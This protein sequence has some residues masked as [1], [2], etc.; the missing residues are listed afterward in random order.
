MH[1]IDIS[2][3]D[4]RAAAAI[5][6]A[7]VTTGFFYGECTTGS[8]WQHTQHLSHCS[9][10]VSNHGVEP[11]IIENQW[12]QNRAFFDLP[13][14]EKLLILA[15]SNGRYDAATLCSQTI[16][17]HATGALQLARLFSA[18][19]TCTPCQLCIVCLAGATHPSLQKAWILSIIHRV[20][21]RKVHEPPPQVNL[22][23]HIHVT[24]DFTHDS[25]ISIAFTTSAILS[26]Y[27]QPYSFLGL[28]TRLSSGIRLQQMHLLV[29]LGSKRVQLNSRCTCRMFSKSTCQTRCRCT[30][31]LSI[32]HTKCD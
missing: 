9:V 19:S 5:L 7:C 25:V 1:V 13:L 27:V 24:T 11:H 20:I 8:E 2:S 3:P 28:R 32:R 29:L 18:H 4:K 10:A 17:C 26:L 30:A 23:C 12:Q 6:Q 22:M 16:Y 21:Q 15:D 31:A 14:K